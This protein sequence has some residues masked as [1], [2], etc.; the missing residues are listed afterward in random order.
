MFNL[1]KKADI[2]LFI[3]LVSIGIILSVLSLSSGSDGAYVRVSVKGQEYGIYNLNE[4]QVIEVKENGHIN[5]IIIKDGFAQMDYSD[6][7]NQ[8]CVK[9]GKISKSNQTIVC[10]PNKVMIEITG[11]EEEFDAV[12]N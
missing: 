8:I 7:K 12:A 10:L 4:D 2:V 3:V 1:I 11:G 9:D 6:C 5:K